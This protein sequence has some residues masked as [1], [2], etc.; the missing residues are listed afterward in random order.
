MDADEGV[1]QQPA[2][3]QR[4]V[5]WIGGDQ[6][7]IEPAQHP[8]GGEAGAAEHEGVEQDQM[9]SIMVINLTGT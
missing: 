1:D 9:N 6:R 3:E 8:L 2:S 4:A 7:A 5:A